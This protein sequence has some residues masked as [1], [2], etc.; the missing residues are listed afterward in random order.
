M[1][2][3]YFMEELLNKLEYCSIFDFFFNSYGHYVIL[4]QL[5]YIL[6]FLI[7]L[8]L[9]IGLL[10]IVF[11]LQFFS[12]DVVECISKSYEKIPI[13]ECLSILML[14]SESELSSVAR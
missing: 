4:F 8:V 13:S 2:R 11:L 7:C 10:F 9:H 1:Y 6:A 5:N 14:H 3:H 12:D